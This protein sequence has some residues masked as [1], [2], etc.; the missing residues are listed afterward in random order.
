VTSDRT[1]PS[2]FGGPGEET[3]SR[4]NE[5]RVEDKKKTETKREMAKNE[6]EINERRERNEC[7]I[8]HYSSNTRT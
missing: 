4:L 2:E 5:A 3:E 6:T 8:E 1:Q 7:E